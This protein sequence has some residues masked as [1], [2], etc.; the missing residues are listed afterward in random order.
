MTLS[1]SPMRSMAKSVVLESL[2]RI[3]VWPECGTP[4]AASPSLLTGAVTI[5]SI[6]RDWQSLTPVSM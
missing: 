4:A 5:P 1:W 2:A 3:S 6:S